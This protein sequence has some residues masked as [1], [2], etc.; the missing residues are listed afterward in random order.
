MSLSE[1]DGGHH[2]QVN[3]AH[4]PAITQATSAAIGSVV[5]NAIVYPLDLVTT[6][7][8]TRRLRRTH[9]RTTT[10]PGFSRQ[11]SLASEFS[12]A[13]TSSSAGGNK[14]R[15]GQQDYGSLVGSFLAIMRSK[16]AAQQQQHGGGGGGG[17]GTYV[18]LLLKFYDG[19]LVDSA[20]TFMNS[21][22]YF[23]I[24]TQLNKRNIERKKRIQRE[25][26][27]L[28]AARDE[29]LIGSLTGIVAKLCTSPLNIITLR[30]QTACSPAIRP[31]S[32]RPA[33]PYTEKKHEHTH[34]LPSSRLVFSHEM[35]S[36]STDEDSSDEDNDE[37][38][39]A[40]TAM[41]TTYVTYLINTIRAIYRER[42]W[43]GFWAGFGMSC[44]LTLHPSLTLYLTKLLKHVSA[45]STATS[46][47]SSQGL[48][49]TFLTS[50]LASSLATCIT[51]P[52][53]LS[54]TLVQTSAH[55]SSSSSSS[56]S[57]ASAH[58]ARQRTLAARYRHFGIA[59]LYSGLQAKLLKVF[60]GQGITMSVKSKIEA[61]FVAIW[62]AASRRRRMPS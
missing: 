29:I 47:G 37:D 58:L 36:S 43:Q 5:S 41:T 20:A 24:Y 51:Y 17:G 4:L 62:I 27:W 15:G 57:L 39:D 44:V 48:L 3:L 30:L 18:G 13:S 22:I 46:T 53:M 14:K 11:S 50:A 26:G 45:T 32:A 12:T 49:A 54:K 31:N 38:D 8:Q 34:A 52:L 7:M 42:G 35:S 1:K 19:I 56:S 59:A 23:Y 21:F 2:P 25:M 55:P 16:K 6:R 40:A 60:V 28:E 33:A 9:N 61:R 10:R